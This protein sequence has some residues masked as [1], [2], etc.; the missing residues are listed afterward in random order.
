MGRADKVKQ[1]PPFGS[2]GIIT[3]FLLNKSSKFLIF[4]LDIF[5][6]VKDQWLNSKTTFNQNSFKALKG[7]FTSVS[8]SWLLTRSTK[9]CVKIVFLLDI[10]VLNTVNSEF[11]LMFYF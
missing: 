11:I 6:K 2:R 10:T 8:M 3:C 9:S 5:Y 4:M 7:I 1:Y